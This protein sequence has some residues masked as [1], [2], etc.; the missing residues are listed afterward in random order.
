MIIITSDNGYI[1]SSFNR[2]K[3]LPEP[4]LTVEKF[5]LKSIYSRL[6]HVSGNYFYHDD[7][8]KWKHFRVTG[9][10]CGEFTSDRWIPLTKA[11]DTGLD[12]FFDLCLNKR[13]SKQSNA[14]D[15]RR[16]RAHYDVTVMMNSCLS[17]VDGNELDL[18]K[19]MFATNG[20]MAITWKH[21][22]SYKT[23]ISLVT[24]KALYFCTWHN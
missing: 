2:N 11:S 22:F 10:L 21:I 3:S 13:F 19:L 20:R 6:E 17:D 4:T 16:R 14:G 24:Y 7:V 8:I 5:Q 12:V 1:G 9:P 15:L 18:Q 23:I